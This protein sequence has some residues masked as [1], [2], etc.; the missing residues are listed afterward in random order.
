MQSRQHFLVL[1]G[2]RGI[3]AISVAIYHGSIIFGG[4]TLLPQAYLAVDFFFMLSGVVVAHAYE[5]RLKAG[6]T[7]DYIQRRAIRLY[8]MI[9]VGA[10]L[11]ASV[12]STSATKPALS[13]WTT[14]M[15]YFLACLCLPVLKD[16]I[17]P[18]S[19]SITPLNVPSW[20]LF[21]EI[22]INATYG[23]MAKSL[24]KNVL[25]SIVIASLLL[26]AIGSYRHQSAN[27]GSQIGE[28]WWG[29]PRVTFPFFTGVLIHRITASGG[30]RTP[31]LP[32]TILAVA[33]MLTFCV[34]VHGPINAVVDLLEI[35]V[36]Y[37]A[38]IVLAMRVKP[39]GKQENRILVWLG[40]LSYPLYII[41]QPI[42]MWLARTK[43]FIGVHLVLSPYLWIFAAISF[44]AICALGIFRFYD[45]PV[46]AW[47]TRMKKQNWRSAPVHQQA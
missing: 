29:F 44:S 22:F 35:A 12:F 46:R 19:H 37:P 7:L 5:A 42:F 47:L 31:I 24:R 32:P 30:L 43:R 16:D 36:L 9:F 41:H 33:L 23:F 11:G 8:P 14:G 18:G 10:A 2:L 13:V 40:L 38:L 45:I 1:D 27:F 3:A 21:F 15:L 20:S 39:P 25:I 34:P 6:Q 17:L 4:K 28:F 26:E